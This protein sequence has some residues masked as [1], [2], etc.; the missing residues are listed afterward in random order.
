MGEHGMPVPLTFRLLRSRSRRG[1]GVPKLAVL[2]GEQTTDGGGSDAAH[3]PLG[4]PARVAGGPL[5]LYIRRPGGLVGQS[6]ISGTTV[7]PDGVQA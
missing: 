1:L 3:E 6:P 4:A 5:H 2:T 7:T